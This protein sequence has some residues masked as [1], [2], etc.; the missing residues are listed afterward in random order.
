MQFVPKFQGVLGQAYLE[1]CPTTVFLLRRWDLSQLVASC[2]G[3]F[4]THAGCVRNSDMYIICRLPHIKAMFK[5]SVYS[6]SYCPECLYLL[7]FHFR[8]SLWQF[9][10]MSVSL[11]EIWKSGFLIPPCKKNAASEVIDWLVSKAAAFCFGHSRR[12]VKHNLLDITASSLCCG[13][14]SVWVCKVCVIM[15]VKLN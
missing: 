9:V 5:C 14:Y 7:W 15:V 8:A 4:V 12:F 10:F 6:G 3:L 2:G 1:R 11:V 13:F